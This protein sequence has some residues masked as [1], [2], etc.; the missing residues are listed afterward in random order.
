MDREKIQKFL[1]AIQNDPGALELMKEMETPSD[2]D[3]AIKSYAGLAGKLGYEI[4]ESDLKE[5]LDREGKR[6]QQKT[7]E[8][9]S[10]I[11]ELP[12]DALDKVAGGQDHDE[13]KVSYKNRENCWF[14]DACDNIIFGYD[15]YICNHSDWSNPCHETATNHKVVKP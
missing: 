9:S 8:A 14:A 1:E 3:E 15:N 13:C 2:Q 4:T 11:Q 5:Y 12:D 6:M 7:E 10:Q